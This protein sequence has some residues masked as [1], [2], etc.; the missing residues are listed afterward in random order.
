MLVI[1][2]R[3]EN[4]TERNISETHRLQRRKSSTGSNL[5]FQL[6]SESYTFNIIWSLYFLAR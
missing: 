4:N 1:C 5:E 3:A 6:P 2:S